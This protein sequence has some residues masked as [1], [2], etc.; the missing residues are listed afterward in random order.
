MKIL[1]VI[2]DCLTTNSSANLC[3]LSYIRGMLDLGNEVDV[4]CASE[5]G[6]KVDGSMKIPD[7]VRLFTY[8]GSSWYEKISHSIHQGAGAVVPVNATTKSRKS[9]LSALKGRIKSFIRSLYGVYGIYAPFI[10][11]AQKFQSNVEYDYII[12]ISSPA[13]SHETAYRLIKKGRV[14]G[15]EWIQI[16]EDPWYADIYGLSH[17]EKIRRAEEKLLQ[18][19]EKVCYVSPLT[20][21][22]QQ[23]I[24]PLAA[25]KMYWQPL[26]TYYKN[27]ET[28]NIPDSLTYGYFGDYVPASRNL[29]PFYKAAVQR[30]SNVYICGNPSNLF[31]ETDTVHI[32][33]RLPLQ[34]LKPIEDRAGIL[35]FLCNRA[36]G[37]IPGKIY[38]YSATDKVILFILDGTKEEKQVLKEYF[39][40]FNRYIFCENDEEDILRAMRLIEEGCF[41]GVCNQGLNDFEAKEI[42]H[43]I[44]THKSETAK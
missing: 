24:F 35:V 1:I 12:S 44:L 4:L 7:G 6:K 18:K 23:Q 13:S 11:R 16:W 43:R 10:R 37:Q 8:S 31:Q 29:A 39:A 9:F 41:E 19:A 14:K 33:P 2:G 3:H 40:A 27:E 22:N 32:Y 5:E 21:C 20:L 28:G 34:Q 17:V 26:P 36:G 25:K 30:K 42:V 38:Q 15:K